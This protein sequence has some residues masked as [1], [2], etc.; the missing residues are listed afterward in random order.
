MALPS[1]R[2][3]GSVQRVRPPDPPGNRSTLVPVE[4]RTL[5]VWEPH[6]HPTH[7]LL[8][9]RAGASTATVG[10]RTWTI[11]PSVGLW[12][13]AGVLHSATAPAGTWYRTAHVDPRTD[14]PLPGGP[15]AVEMT[16]L[17]TLLLER[18]VDQSLEAL[19]RAHR[20]DGVRPTRAVP[21]RSARTAS[22]FGAPP[23]DR[24]R[25]RGQPGR[26]ALVDGVGGA[27]GCERADHHPGLSR[28]HGV[29]LRRLAGG[30]PRSAGRAAHGPRDDCGRGG[31]AGRVQLRQRVR[32][33]VP[34]DHRPDPGPIPRTRGVR[35]AT[36]RVLIK[37]L[38]R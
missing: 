23:A 13:P 24:H 2:S 16:P 21:A 20:A 36:P 35:S 5:P 28:G 1:P 31:R 11:T 30:L 8:W 29:E 15:V 32:S 7:E 37:R 10:A 38:R 4:T 3:R 17:L 33:G 19:A 6:S 27:A 14:S 9:N 26:P 22:R 34:P 12:I 18:L 25:T